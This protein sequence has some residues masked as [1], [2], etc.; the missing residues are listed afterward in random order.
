[1]IPPGD[2]V[3]PSPFMIKVAPTPVD[4]NEE[5]RAS[6]LVAIYHITNEGLEPTLAVLSGVVLE[7]GAEVDLPDLHVGN[8]LYYLKSWKVGSIEFVLAQYDTIIGW[9]EN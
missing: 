3:R 8:V 6:G 7:I 4:P 5:Q 1:M 9:E 2:S